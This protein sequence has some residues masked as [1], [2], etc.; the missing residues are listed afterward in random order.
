MFK[1]QSPSKH[2][3]LDA[4]HPSRSFFHSSV[5]MPVSASA[6]LFHL[7]HVGK[8]FPCKDFFHPGKTKKKVTQVKVR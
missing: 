1:L 5:L 8:T 4:V 3:A 6:I 7:F 2:S